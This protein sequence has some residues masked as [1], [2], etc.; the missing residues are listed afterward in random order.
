MNKNL[1]TLAGL[2]A[3]AIATPSFAADVTIRLTGSTAMRSNVHSILTTG[4]GSGGL[5][6]TNTAWTTNSASAAASASYHVYKKGTTGVDEVTILTSWSGSVAGIQ[7]AAQNLTGLKFLPAATADV[8]GTLATSTAVAD[9]TNPADIAF[10]DVWQNASIFNTP[11]LT[12]TICGI[13]Q[14]RFVTNNTSGT[15][16]NNSPITNIT[17][18]QVRVLYQNGTLP[19]SAFTGSSADETKLVY[20]FGRDP[21]SGTRVTAFAENGLGTNPTV[22]Q[23]KATVASGAVTEIF[24]YAAQTLFDQTYGIGNSGESSGGT[25]ANYLK[26]SGSSVKLRTATGVTAGETTVPQLYAVGYL[27]T[28]DAATAI[29]GSTPGSVIAYNGVNPST[30]GTALADAI[31]AGSYHFWSYLHCMHNGVTGDKLT[32]YSDITTKLIAATSGNIKLADMRVERF[33][34]GGTVFPK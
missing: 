25:L 16:P 18:Q 3:F 28:S 14:F 23:Y 30:S 26:A 7:A 2:A 31:K 5:G 32:F 12:D 33:S 22:F 19:L 15:T 29:G 20:A 17:P 10:S 34:D 1:L 8:T 4:T 21:D 27:G 11:A 9:N 6:F 24:P 13:V